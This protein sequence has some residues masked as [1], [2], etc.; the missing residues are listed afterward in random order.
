MPA[1]DAKNRRQTHRCH[2]TL[3]SLRLSGA[4]PSDGLLKLRSSNDSLPAKDVE[5]AF[6]APTS[7]RQ[8]AL[9]LTGCSLPS[10]PSLICERLKCPTERVTLRAPATSWR[11]T[12]RRQG[13]ARH[14][15]ISSGGDALDELPR[16]LGLTHVVQVEGVQ[17]VCN[18][19]QSLDLAVNVGRIERP[20]AVACTG[21]QKRRHAPG[22]P[23]SSSVVE[24]GGLICAKA[25]PSK[26]SCR[27]LVPADALRAFSSV[28][29][30]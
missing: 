2:S 9:R 15:P 1:L 19:R 26:L 20:A 16:E 4:H 12:Q 10:V 27:T 29:K 21:S 25:Q 8:R 18:H 30:P 3:N 5:S 23:A 22:V 14:V 6:P 17:S 11:P 24:L 13:R 28:L 7:L